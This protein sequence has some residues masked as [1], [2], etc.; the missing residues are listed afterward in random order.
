MPRVQCP[1]C[2]TQLELDATW[3]GKQGRC[4][5]C[6]S[7][8]NI[9]GPAVAGQ[10]PP[11]PPELP[12]QPGPRQAAPE[13]AAR[14]PQPWMVVGIAASAALVLVL[15]LLLAGRGKSDPDPDDPSLAGNPK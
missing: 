8:L 5:N 3:A 7:V 6:R 10:P 13:T 12:D 15:A 1:K 14:R 9:P 11:K 2:K 4:P